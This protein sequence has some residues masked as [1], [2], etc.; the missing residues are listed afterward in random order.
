MTLRSALLA[1]LSAGPLTGYD[2]S[3]RFGASVGFVWSASDSQIYP[4]LRKMQAEEL[5][6]GEEVPW[7]SKGATK[8][9]YAL[10]DKGWEALK[11]AWIAPIVYGPNRDPARLK[12]AYFE[13]ASN[14]DARRHL[15]AH[16]AHFEKMKI[17]SE[18]M[19]EELEAKTHPTLARRL[20]GAPDE[21]HVRIVAFKVL[22]YEGQIAHAQAEIGWAEKGLKLLDVL[23]SGS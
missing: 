18:S 22:A 5:L 3:Q 21:E 13:I 10:S 14:A 19:I 20:A 23:G 12:S 4:E 6:V 17:Q 7:G 2:A 8:T 1:L 16:I 15:R 11:K 9:E